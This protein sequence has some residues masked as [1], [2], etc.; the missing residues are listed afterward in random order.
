MTESQLNKD[1][2]SMRRFTA[3]ASETED[4]S[5]EAAE[6][7]IYE[8]EDPENL[9]EDSKAQS[10]VLFRNEDEDVPVHVW[11]AM[12]D[13]ERFTGLSNKETLERNEG[14]LFDWGNMGHRGLTMRS[15][16]FPIDMVFLDK[17]GF[18]QQIV[19]R[20][21]PEDPR[22]YDSACRYAIELSAGFCEKN[23]ISTDTRVY[24]EVR[25]NSPDLI[26]LDKQESIPEEAEHYV[27]EDEVPEGA[28]TIEGPAGGTYYIPPNEDSE[29]D[30]DSS[31]EVDLSERD[32][33][34][35]DDSVHPAKWRRPEEGELDEYIDEMQDTEFWSGGH[36]FFVEAFHG[37]QSTLNDHTN[38]KGELTEE[39]RQ[40]H[41]EWASELLNEKAATDPDETPVGM[42]VLG[43]PGAGKGWW[44]EQ[45][46]EGEYGDDL[47]GRNFTQIYSDRT[48]EPI[49]EYDGS[50]AAEVHDEASRMAKE[51]LA[52]QAFEN[53]HNVVV[54]KVATSPEST[55]RM[56][57]AM[58]EAGY[59]IRA[60]FVDVPE[61]KSVHNDVGRYEEEG[62]FTPPEYT[63]SARDGS[64]D[65]FEQIIEEADIPEEKVGRFNNVVEWGEAPEAE[66]LGDELLKFLELLYPDTDIHK[67]IYN[68]DVDTDDDRKTRRRRERRRDSGVAES[69]LRRGAD[70]GSG[71]GSGERRRPVLIDLDKQDDGPESPYIEFSNLGGDPFETYDDLEDFVD[72]LFEAGAEQVYLGDEVFGEESGHHDRP[73][74]V[75]GLSEAEAGS[76]YED[77]IDNVLAI[78]EPSKIEHSGKQGTHS[79][80][81]VVTVDSVNEA[82]DEVIVHY[83][84]DRGLYYLPEDVDSELDDHLSQSS[85]SGDVSQDLDKEGYEY[86]DAPPDEAQPEVSQAVDRFREEI[87]E[88][89]KSEEALLYWLLGTSTP[90]YKMSKE[91]AGYQSTPNEGSE[92]CGSC[93]YLYQSNETG[94]LICSKI[95]GPVDWM[96]WCRLWDGTEPDENLEAIHGPPE[97]RE[98]AMQQDWYPITVVEAMAKQMDF[99][100]EV[101]RIVA[102]D[103]MDMGLTSDLM[104]VGVN[105]P[106]HDVFVDWRTE[107]WP[108]GQELDG[109]H[110]SIYST[111]DDVRDVAQGEVEMITSVDPSGGVD[112]QFETPPGVPDNAN[113]LAPDEEPP[114]GATT[115]EGPQGATYYVTDDQDPDAAPQTD[116]FGG[117]EGSQTV[118][119]D[120]QVAEED[121]D[122]F[123]SY[124][125]GSYRTMNSAL[126]GNRE[127]TES[128]QEQI[129]TIESYMDQVD[130]FDEPT[131]VYRGLTASADMVEQFSN[132]EG[133]QIQLSGFQSTS[134]NPQAADFFAGPAIRDDEQPV[135]MNIETPRGLPLYD[136][137]IDRA[138]AADETRDEEEMLLGH[139]WT[140]EIQNVE[141]TEDGLLVDLEVVDD[142]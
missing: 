112:K 25:D 137:G 30:G 93:E 50:N 66:Q 11:V 14:M 69:E 3:L 111:M 110:V 73:V 81:E 103:D 99:E 53:E 51:E 117:L 18:V 16:D 80:D 55:I 95:A 108:D 44:Q 43:P 70:R 109:P 4:P 21:Q 91:D 142:E 79:T 39:R 116:N 113:Y 35:G 13:D 130:D 118:D 46:A 128:T 90:A 33:E 67:F 54:D 123:V 62:R 65:S 77:H 107:S 8:V 121:Q 82:P 34:I 126:R 139:D 15:M 32:A 96:G 20:V 57:K 74:R 97:S 141:E 102:T 1:G 71:G 17:D 89:V 101:F 59:D 26:D 86:P 115:H 12:S 138:G 85:S 5:R 61:E 131:T 94:N 63:A 129:D 119:T 140:Y 84:E 76:V 9:P 49:P 24:R 114:E 31:S 78:T 72:D 6:G 38:E 134:H 124:M 56:V 105:F 133:D 132:G 127:M 23:G 58:Q 22:T 60:S 104:A 42:I 10:V 36:E 37:D 122:A 64:Q 28:R 92:Y 75:E 68:G 136:M 48:K 2:M 40:Q 19:E 41:E 135:M 88:E 45:V 52:P 7:D 47:G 125:A 83:D 87:P 27:D 100:L 106:S 120:T 98:E 29:S